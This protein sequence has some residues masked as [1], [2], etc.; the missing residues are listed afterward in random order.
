MSKFTIKEKIERYKEKNERTSKLNSISTL[1]QFFLLTFLHSNVF[2]LSFFYIRKHLLGIFSS[3]LF[4]LRCQKSPSDLVCDFFSISQQWIRNTLLH[5]EKWL[6]IKW[7]RRKRNTNKSN[8]QTY[9]LYYSL[10]SLASI[11]ISFTYTSFRYGSK[12]II[13]IV[14]EKRKTWQWLWRIKRRRPK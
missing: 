14:N 6:K 9:T 7:L 12:K 4:R 13:F 5:S 3:C 11:L 2:F 10:F 1:N 8:S